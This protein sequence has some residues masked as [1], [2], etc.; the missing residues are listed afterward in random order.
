MAKM[1]NSCVLLINKVS[2]IVNHKRKSMIGRETVPA[3]GA[4]WELNVDESFEMK[5]GSRADIKELVVISSPKCKQGKLLYRIE[6]KGFTF[7]DEEG[8]EYD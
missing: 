8:I 6:S 2:D 3:L 4:S 5:K 1:T 7:I